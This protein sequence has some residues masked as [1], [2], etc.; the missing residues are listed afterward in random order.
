MENKMKESEVIIEIFNGK[1]I[2]KDS[3]SC[4]FGKSCSIK[5]DDKTF[6]IA[7]DLCGEVYVLEK[8]KYFSLNY[9]ENQKVR[10]ILIKYGFE[11]PCI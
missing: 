6:C 2:I 9:E 7:S 10:S 3:P 5:I 4:G 8:D 11:F 1:L